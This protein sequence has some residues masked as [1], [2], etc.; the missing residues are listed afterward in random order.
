MKKRKGFRAGTSS[1]RLDYRSGG[2]VSKEGNRLK[3][4]VGYGAITYPAGINFSNFDAAAF[5][6]AMEKNFANIKIDP[7]TTPGTPEYNEAQS[8]IKGTPQYREA[9]QM[10]KEAD[11][12]KIRNQLE[13]EAAGRGTTIGTMPVQTLA[14]KAREGDIASNTGQLG[15]VEKVSGTT[16]ETQAPEQVSTIQDTATV[17]QPETLTTQ[18]ISDVDTV[19]ATPT[20]AAVGTV[21]DQ[22]LTAKTDVTSVPTITGVDVDVKEGALTNRI[23]AQ[24]SPEAVAQAAQ[25][26]GLDVR[27]V[28]RAKEELRTAGID[29]LTI[30]QLGNDPTTLEAKLMD[31]TDK[32][33]GLV[34]GLPEEALVSTQMNTLLEGIEQGTIPTWAKPAVAQVDALL[35]QRGL[36]ASSVGRDALLNT[37]IQ[38][39]LP[40][41]QQNAQAIQSSLAQERGIEAQVAIKEAE[42]KQQTALTN[43]NNVFQLDLAQ[44]SADQQT[45][46]SNSKFLQ[47]VSLTEASNDQQAAI[48]NAVLLSQ[49][50]LTQATL[51]QQRLINNS[52]AFLQIDMANLNNEQQSRIIESQQRQQ[53]LLS[54][55]AA[56]N[57]AKQ[58]NATSVNQMNQFMLS[59]A[60]DTNKFNTTQQNAIKQF[61][62]TQ[63]NAA[64]AR[65][66]QRTF[67]LTKFNTGI[68]NQIEQFNITVENNKKEFNARNSLAIAQS[69][70]QWRRQVATADTAAVNAAAEQATKMNFE[71]T[72]QAQQA[73]W[74][75]M[76]DQAHNLFT[77]SRKDKDIVAQLTA[78]FL[79][80][81]YANKESM[82]NSLKV[83][84]DVVTNLTDYSVNTYI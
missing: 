56:Q 34:A 31:L 38:S 79:S 47:T 1:I 33:R 67:D 76:R 54:N 23:V 12:N 26:S 9:Q 7:K 70:A 24:M 81:S 15:S 48:Q 21:S 53:T 50:N 77:A 6:A 13:Q 36:E 63:Q 71:L 29:E 75:D 84:K 57:A 27:R 25:V 43:A 5:N 10:A 20:Q 59:L 58:F 52:K 41:A 60:Q 17:A 28:T 45:A 51:D 22:S 73:L 4:N 11:V 16:A 8:K 68:R 83:L 74:Q 80:G 66:A 32:D 14:S 69:N 19:T 65:D 61:N 62:V 35:A 30:S 44:F 39:A 40:L 64:A 37:I 42:F 78:D 46:L 82:Q 55:Q 3:A 2:L 49:Q 18:Q 72:A